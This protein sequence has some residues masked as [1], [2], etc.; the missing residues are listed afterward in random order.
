MCF[1]SGLAGVAVGAQAAGAVG[2]TYA[3][4]RKSAGEQQGYEYQGQVAKNNAQLAE[5]QAQDAIT[6]GV[7]TRQR[8]ELKGAAV[9]G[10]QRAIF[11]AR[12]VAANEGSALNI[13]ADTAYGTAL[14]AATATD[15]AA[16]E[17]WAL[18]NQA[19]GYASNAAFLASRADAQSPW[20]DAAGTA[21]TAGGRVAESWYSFDKSAHAAGKKT[22]S[23]FG[24]K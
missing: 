17:A 7:T 6:R 1:G 13:L 16:K 23:F 5:W 18:R 15:N 4:Y 21:L 10:R 20:L 3:A 9:A 14:D 24:G 2:S 8:V 22:V 12:N 19:T 11:G